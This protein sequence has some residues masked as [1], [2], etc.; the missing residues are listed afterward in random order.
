MDARRKG[1]KHMHVVRMMAWGGLD[2]AIIGMQ[3]GAYAEEMHHAG[4]AVFCL[5]SRVWSHR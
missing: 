5:A 3:Q 1:L 2:E 4:A